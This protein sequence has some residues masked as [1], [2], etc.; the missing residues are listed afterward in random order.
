MKKKILHFSVSGRLIEFAKLWFNIHD[1]VIR[2]LSSKWSWVL[3]VCGNR[4]VMSRRNDTP[5]ER[6]LRSFF[7]ISIIYYVICDLIFRSWRELL[8][9]C[10]SLLLLLWLETL[11]FS[12]F[13]VFG[14]Y[15]FC[16]VELRRELGGGEQANYSRLWHGNFTKLVSNAN[17]NSNCCYIFIFAL[18]K[19]RIFSQIQKRT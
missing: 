8:Q 3:C 1:K 10:I 7:L 5:F 14:L 9:I 19:R 12:A 16:W 2:I 18:Q 13:S 15:F 11:V 6:L 17:S 4:K